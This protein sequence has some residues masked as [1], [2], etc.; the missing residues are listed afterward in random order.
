MVDNARRLFW[1]KST[2]LALN[3][4]DRGDLIIFISKISIIVIIIGRIVI[5]LIINPSYHHHCFRLGGLG[6]T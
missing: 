1:N 3:W 4:V 2:R 5:I 6:A